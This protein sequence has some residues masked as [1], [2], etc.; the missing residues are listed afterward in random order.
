MRSQPKEPEHRERD[1]QNQ[2][3]LEPTAGVPLMLRFWVGREEEGRR[4]RSWADED[5]TMTLRQRSYIRLLLFAVVVSDSLQPYGLQPTRLL[6][7]QDSAGKI[8]GVGCH[9]LLQGIFRT[10]RLNLRLLHLLYWLA[11]SLSLTPPGKPW[12]PYQESSLF[13]SQS[14]QSFAPGQSLGNGRW[15]VWISLRRFLFLFFIFQNPATLIMACQFP[16]AGLHLL[17]DCYF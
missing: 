9:A 4:D 5:K 7:P 10:Q 17:Y 14:G 8:T 12:I 2:D 16:G 11:G 15:T 1:L 3:Y 6:C 13:M